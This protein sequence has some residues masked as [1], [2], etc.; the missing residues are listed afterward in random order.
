VNPGHTQVIVVGGGQAGLSVSYYLKQKG[1]AHVVLEKSRVAEAWR[2]ERWDSF[3][4]VTPNWQCRLPGF[5]YSGSD[6]DGFM[7]K[8][9]VVRY[10]EAF[11]EHFDPPVRQGVEVYAVR[12]NP[13]LGCF[14]VATSEGE[15]AA[16][17]VV[18]AT[19]C[20]HKP[21][22][23][24][25]AKSIPEHIEQLHSSQYRKPD[26]LPP[27]AI[28]VAGSGQSGCQIA[29]DL[30]LAGRSVHLCLGDA[31]R[32]PRMYRGRDV[33]AWLDGFGYYDT[34][35]DAHPDV[36]MVRNKTNHYLT[37]RDGGRDIDLRRFAIEGMKLYG[38]MTGY[39]DGALKFAPDLKQ[40]LDSA[41]DVYRGICKLIDDYI[42]KNDVEA[43]PPTR[44]E[45]CWEPEHNPTSL[46][47]EHSDISA[48]I[49]SIGY[50]SDFSF[51]KSPVFDRKGYPQHQRGITP[52]RGLYF[53]G[54]SWLHTWGSAR[55]SGVATD[56]EYIVEHIAANDA[57]RRTTT[58]S[59]ASGSSQTATYQ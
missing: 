4:L 25:F 24:A 8:D 34:P 5:A 7:L 32:S 42:E 11:A 20:F 12:K 45:P 30:H 3:C 10:I 21:R 35:I 53:I 58:T 15:Y 2:S 55:L 1:I 22:I 54:L 36:D 51:V 31:P 41:D 38:F 18:I 27:G 52:E 9:E 46:D 48:L 17:S 13:L 26:A 56:A 29:E 6:P 23:P 14:E 57:R 19:G 28:V 16:D 50:Q 40:R 33:V 37:G 49:W 44:Y 39:D 47:L 59:E 43:P